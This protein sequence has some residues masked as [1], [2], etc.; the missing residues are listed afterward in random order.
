MYVCMHVCMYVCVCV[1]VSILVCV[2]IYIY[3]SMNI[4]DKGRWV[5]GGDSWS[6]PSP[7]ILSALTVLVYKALTY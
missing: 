6:R 5:A 3:I 2:C 1:C 4:D 7:P